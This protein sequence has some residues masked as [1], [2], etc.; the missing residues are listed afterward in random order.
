MTL[1][2]KA[3]IALAAVV[4]LVPLYMLSAGPAH[5]LCY[6][7]WISLE[8]YVAYSDPAIS[9]A[10]MIGRR[11]HTTYIQY[12]NLWVPSFPM[13]EVDEPESDE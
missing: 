9:L 12:L 11:G 13:D 7:D 6:E 8:A 5:R 10:G 4:V 3:K 2:N 1:A